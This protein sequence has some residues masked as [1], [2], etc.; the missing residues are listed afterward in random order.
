MTTDIDFSN[1]LPDIPDE[2][3]LPEWVAKTDVFDRVQSVWRMYM[4]RVPVTEIARRHINPATNNPY[5]VQQMYRDLERAREFRALTLMKES[6]ANLQEQIARHETLIQRAN[7]HLHLLRSP[8]LEWDSRT[9]EYVPRRDNEG[10][11]RTWTPEDSKA[12]LELMKFIAAEE[13]TIEALQ[14]F[15]LLVPRAETP[16]SMQDTTE[17]T[18]VSVKTRPVMTAPQEAFSDP[19]AEASTIIDG[20]VVSRDKS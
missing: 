11:P 14:G 7:E 5:S 17:V 1:V 19:F 10:N 8:Y 3:K 15:S 12:S 18:V 6:H 9:E 13:K 16:A 4:E 2:M 20:D